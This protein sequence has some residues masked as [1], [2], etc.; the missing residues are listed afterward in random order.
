VLLNTAFW[1]ENSDRLTERFNQW[2]AQK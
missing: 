2:A 1:L